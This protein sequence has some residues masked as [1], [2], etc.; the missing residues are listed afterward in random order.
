[1]GNTSYNIDVKFQSAIEKAGLMA[2]EVTNMISILNAMETQIDSMTWSGNQAADFK[3]RI[4]DAKAELD[5]VYKNY[6]SKIPE[7]IENSITKYKTEEQ[8]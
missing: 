8:G 2:Q 6:V 5:D 4:S 1:M 7:Q 3:K